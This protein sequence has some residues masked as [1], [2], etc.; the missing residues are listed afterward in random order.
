MRLLL[1]A[2]ALMLATS[3]TADAG[4]KDKCFKEANT[5]KSFCRTTIKF[6]CKV[7]EDVLD[8]V[9][10]A[11]KA[12]CSSKS[13]KK[14]CKADHKSDEKELD[15]ECKFAKKE[16]KSTRSAEKDDCRALAGDIKSCEDICTA[17]CISSSF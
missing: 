11:C 6:D 12:A 14:E 17:T 5:A 2:I 7:F 3:Y 8:A 15:E 9:K 4:L 10:D 1:A 16:C 13:C